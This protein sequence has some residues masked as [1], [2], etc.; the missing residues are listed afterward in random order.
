MKCR[1]MFTEKK[2]K[3]KKNVVCY[4][5]ISGLRGNVTP[6]TSAYEEKHTQKKQQQQQQK[7]KLQNNCHSNTSVIIL[8]AYV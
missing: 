8:H 3:K 2:K 7:K 4:N 1:L 6:N 5:L